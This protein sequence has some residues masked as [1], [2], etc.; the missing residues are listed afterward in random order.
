VRVAIVHDWLT[1]MRGG[2]QVLASL[3]R[4]L[5]GAPI[6]TLLWIRGSV[7]PEIEAHPIRTSFVQ[8]LPGV[9]T[10]YRSYLPL[11]P[12]A[13]ER[14]NLRGFDLVVS[15]SHCVAKGAIAGPGARHVSYVHS[16]VRYAWDRFGDYFGP[17]SAGRLKRLAATIVTRRLRRWDA[18][19]AHRVDRFIANSRFV[20]G[21]IHRYYGREAE[22]IHPPVDISRFPPAAGPPGDYYLM[23]SALNPYKR[24]HH[25]VEAC[26]R[27]GRRLVVAGWGP[28]AKRLRALAERLGGDV[29]FAGRVSDAEIV[30][31]YAGCRALLFPGVEDFGIT[32]LEAMASGRPVI[33]LAEGGAL[34]T[35]V[36]VGAEAGAA[37]T[38]V[39]Y[40][41]PDPAGL[42]AAIERFEA[43]PSGFDPV[44]LRAHAG[45]FDRPRFEEAL[46]RVLA[47]EGAVT[48]PAA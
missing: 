11:F 1:G 30:R 14:L 4:L 8:R 23:V 31:L 48:N 18:G 6:Y 36:P 17:G 25:A 43:D 19:T 24:V 33:A 34:E 28:W 21:R 20:A 10:H 39:L 9:R 15:T 47:E 26:A 5:P 44:A 7:S 16:P 29:R 40:A 45:R 13:I 32:P 27:L 22:V 12:A 38:G 41:Q 2:E 37:P 3:C 42:A 46:G 35:V